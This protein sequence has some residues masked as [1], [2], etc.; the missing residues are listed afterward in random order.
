MNPATERKYQELLSN[1]RNKNTIKLKEGK[2]A[3]RICHKL[4][5]SLEYLRLHFI[6]SHSSELKQLEEQ[7]KFR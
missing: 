2:C 5:R 6:N 7:A 1:F 4:F 3:C